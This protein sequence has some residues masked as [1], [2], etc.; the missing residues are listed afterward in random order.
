VEWLEF[1]PQYHT[2]KKKKKTHV[3][4][5]AT[6]LKLESTL[7]LARTAHVGTLRGE[8]EDCSTEMALNFHLHILKKIIIQFSMETKDSVYAEQHWK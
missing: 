6:S 2:K 7:Q 1:K 8:V 4:K 5:A 3:G